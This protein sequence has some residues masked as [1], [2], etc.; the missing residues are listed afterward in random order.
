MGARENDLNPDTW[1]GLSFPLGRSETGL[2][3]QTKTTLQQARHNLKNLLL[4]RRGERPM[5]PEFGSRL[6]SFLFEPIE[7]DQMR[8]KIE[9]EILNTT[10]QWLPYV[11]IV[12]I[13]INFNDRDNNR[14]TI[15]ISFNISLNP[16]VIE[17]IA[18]TYES[19]DY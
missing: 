3:K 5:Q 18:L 19:G 6:Y 9:E 16:E 11:N 1:I 8:D 10:S 17:Q 13:N 7:E 12:D 4:T 2:F 14:I 15:T